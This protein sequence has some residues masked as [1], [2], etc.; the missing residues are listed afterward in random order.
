RRLDKKDFIFDVNDALET[1]EPV[2]WS[3]LSMNTLRPDLHF[4]YICYHHSR[5]LWSHL[6][7][8]ADLDL[9]LR[10][11]KLDHSQIQ[12]TAKQ[13]GLTP[14]TDASVALHGLLSRPD[15]W[16]ESPAEQGLEGEF[17]NACLSNLSGGMELEYELRQH[18]F[19]HDLM[20]KAQ[21]SPEH[22]EATRDTIW[23]NKFRPILEQYLKRPLPHALFWMY[24]VQRALVVFRDSV[25]SSVF[26]ETNS[27]DRSPSKSK[28]P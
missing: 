27:M 8:L 23:R 21:I 4:T 18:S 24:R 20:S 17:L 15:E 12:Q 19:G 1:A 9:M 10:S 26:G 6:H 25:Y 2:K 5:H 7:W 28:D 3:G 14:T 11:D 13:V 16:L 22:L